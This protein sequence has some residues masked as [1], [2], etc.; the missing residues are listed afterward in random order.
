MPTTQIPADMTVQQ[1]DEQYFEEFVNKDFFKK[2]TSTS[3]DSMIQVKEDLTKKPGDTIHVALRNRLKGKAKK[4]NELLE[5]Q[6]EAIQW[7]DFQVKIDEYSHPVKWRDFDEQKTAIDLR[8][9]HKDALMVWNMELQRDKIIEALGSIDGVPYNDATPTQRNT[10]LGN[11]SDRVLFG[12]VKA[13]N[14]GVH[15]TSV[16]NVDSVNDKLTSVAIKQMKRIAKA[17]TPKIS[18]LMPRRTIDAADYF[19]MFIH[20]LHER[21]LETDTAFMSANR[22]ARLR[23]LDNPIFSGANY[24]FGNVAI[25]SIEEMP[26]YTGVGAAGIDVA[27]V[28][29]CGQQAI[30]TAWAKRPWTVSD[31]RSFGQLKAL[32]VRQWYECRKAQFGSGPNDKDNL[33]DFGVCTGFFSAVPD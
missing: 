2:F 29:L 19:V 13:N 16:A 7:R 1:W 27:P 12:A 11:N 30:I 28:Y 31:D 25:Y 14:T 33:K 3:A 17:G 9:A 26:V 15:A 18:P 5:G 21:D 4:S 23:G 20:P 22:D 8:E 6:E 10:W 24:I 32:A